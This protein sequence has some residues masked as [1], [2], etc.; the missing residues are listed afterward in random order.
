[1]EYIRHKRLLALIG[2]ITLFLGTILPYLSLNIFGYKQNVAL[3][4]Y[5]EGKI[6]ILLI[7]ANAFFIFKDYIEKYIPR[8]FETNIGKKLARITNQKLSL[9]P[10]ILIVVFVIYLNTQF[11]YNSEFLK[12]GL[13][14]YLLWLGVIA[15]V[16]HAILYKK[17][18]IP[19]EIKSVGNDY[20][21]PVQKTVA[22]QEINTT[23][24]ETQTNNNSN[25]IAQNTEQVT[26]EPQPFN[27]NASVFDNT[28]P[29][30][31]TNQVE[32]TTI[33]NKKYC[34]KC[35]AEVNSGVTRCP[36]CGNNL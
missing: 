6:V 10:T 23:V 28:T 19:K 16:G 18:D 27:P 4:G 22:P 3:I 7:I 14:F 35:G 11:D 30:I 1:M 17:S 21:V 36:M 34:P 20:Q 25:P 15:L 31:K 13:G 26:N 9:I 33:N 12:N 29:P 2:L 8:L 5:W 32:S 24:S